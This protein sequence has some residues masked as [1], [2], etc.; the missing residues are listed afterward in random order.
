MSQ[1]PHQP[2]DAYCLDRCPEPRCDANCDCSTLK[3]MRQ[4]E[5]RRDARAVVEYIATRHRPALEVDLVRRFFVDEQRRHGLDERSV[6]YL[7][8]EYARLLGENL[9]RDASV[10]RWVLEGSVIAWGGRGLAPVEP[11]DATPVVVSAMDAQPAV[12]KI[13]TSNCPVSIRD[14]VGPAKDLGPAVVSAQEQHLADELREQQG[15]RCVFLDLRRGIG[16]H[17]ASE[18][19][20]RAHLPASFRLR[21]IP[22]AA[23]RIEERDAEDTDDWVDDSEDA[24]IGSTEYVARLDDVASGS[25]IL[26]EADHFLF[27]DQPNPLWVEIADESGQ[28]HDALIT[29]RGRRR[30]IFGLRCLFLENGG[31]GM[32]F[33]FRPTNSPHMFFFDVRGHIDQ[34]PVVEEGLPRKLWLYMAA[35]QDYDGWCTVDEL[36]F[37][38]GALPERLMETL[39]GYRCFQTREGDGGRPLWRLNPTE[40]RLERPSP[41]D[42]R[43]DDAAETN[44]LLRRMFLETRG[45]N[46]KLYH[47]NSSLDEMVQRLRRLEVTR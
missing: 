8:R 17:W 5:V 18:E 11:E 43:H 28:S 30:E 2:L 26:D 25:V 37:A 10:Q 7:E 15:V 14:L 13:L 19:W 41:E 40:P 33:A 21:S 4:A 12:L 24:E 31:A 6:E 23:F 27:P 20:L 35:R 46:L 3:F 44:E 42:D 16:T 38:T 45:W 34:T 29:T 22:E 39:N 36:A 9:L 1:V 32:K 47:L